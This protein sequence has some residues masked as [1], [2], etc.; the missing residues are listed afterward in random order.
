MRNDFSFPDGLPSH[1]TIDKKKKWERGKRKKRKGGGR[2][3]RKCGVENV[4]VMYVI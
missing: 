1:G 2:V 3:R 4:R